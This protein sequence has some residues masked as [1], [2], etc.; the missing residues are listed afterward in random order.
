MVQSL[1]DVLE[2]LGPMYSLQQDLLPARCGGSQQ[3]AGC[4]SSSQQQLLRLIGYEC[5]TVDELARLG[6]VPVSRVMA[7]VTFLEIRGAVARCDG[8]YIRS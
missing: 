4:F 8:G 6:A 2:E 7:D 1:Q 3:E 5:I